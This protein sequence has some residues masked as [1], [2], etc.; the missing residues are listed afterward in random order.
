MGEILSENGIGGDVIHLLEQK[1]KDIFKVTNLRPGREYHIVRQDSCSK[2]CALVYE[3]SPLHYV[4]YDLRDSVSINLYER[5]FET[6][7]E[8]AS[9]EIETSLWNTLS[10]RG[11]NPAIIDKME[12]ALASSVDF[13]HTQKE[14][15]S[16]SF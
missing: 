3:P 14:I 11:V 2:A 6:C 4:V 15:S 12:D 1:A 10:E 8:T 7:V 5:A 16:K 13:Y 9:G